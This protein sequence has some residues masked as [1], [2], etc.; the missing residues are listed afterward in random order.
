[1]NKIGGGGWAGGMQ[2][3]LRTARGG[4]CTATTAPEPPPSRVFTVPACPLFLPPCQR[5]DGGG[6]ALVHAARGLGCA[7]SLSRCWALLLPDHL[8]PCSA[9]PRLLGSGAACARK[10]PKAPSLAPFVFP[11]PIAERQRYRTSASAAE[12]AMLFEVHPLV[13]QHMIPRWGTGAGWPCWSFP[14][15]CFA[16]AVVAGVCAQHSAGWPWPRF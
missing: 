4:A 15:C 3:P 2:A 7:F 5:Q 1:M 13:I 6:A 16:V 8:L 14:A 12:V 9:A 11:A 10:C